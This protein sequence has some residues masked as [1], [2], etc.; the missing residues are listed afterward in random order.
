LR[1]HADSSATQA[2]ILTRKL[3]GLDH[4]GMPVETRIVL[5]PT[6]RL[7]RAHVGTLKAMTT[8]PNLYLAAGT[9]SRRRCGA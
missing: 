5:D 4:D 8:I 1:R 7:T 2:L 6:A 3:A 9:T